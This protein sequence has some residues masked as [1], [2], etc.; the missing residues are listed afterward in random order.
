MNR[1][2]H[3]FCG[4]LA[5]RG[6]SSR[7]WRAP[8]GAQRRQG[9]THGCI[10]QTPLAHAWLPA[11]LGCQRERP[12]A[13]WLATRSRRLMSEV[14]STVTIGS[15]ESR[16][17]L[18]GT[19][20]LREQALRSRAMKGLDH[21]PHCWDSATDERHAEPGRLPTCIGEHHG[22][23]RSALAARRP[24]LRCVRSAD[25]KGRTDRGAFLPIE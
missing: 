16:L 12:Q 19:V 2:R 9:T 21:V 13:G 7:V 24:L 10:V 6:W 14:S 18:L 23:T 5:D 11:H 17:G 15:L 20:G 4:H 22:R 25:V 8:G 1:S 3:V